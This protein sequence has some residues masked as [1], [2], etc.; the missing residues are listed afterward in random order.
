MRGASLIT[1]GPWPGEGR[2]LPPSRK[3]VRTRSQPVRSWRSMARRPE[4]ARAHLVAAAAVVSRPAPC[5]HHPPPPG[6]RSAAEVAVPL[7]AD[8]PELP[9]W[10]GVGVHLPQA[11]WYCSPTLPAPPIWPPRL[12]VVRPNAA[13]GRSRKGSERKPGDERGAARAGRAH[14]SSRPTL[15]PPTP[16]GE[17]PR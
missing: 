4:L 12:T 15:T 9:V 5:H 17:D 16:R 7:A 2:V 8:R 11:S 1:E 13:H 10:G 3:R 14:H 6:S